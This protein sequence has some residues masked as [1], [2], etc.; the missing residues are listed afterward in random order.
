MIR[1]F[2]K[3]ALS[4][5]LRGRL[6]LLVVF[7]MVPVTLLTV[8]SGWR[9]RQETVRAAEENLQ[10]VT[11][12]AAANEAR[13]IE[14]AR[15]F[16]T[17]L[18]SVPDVL[19]GEASC[20]AYLASL[21]HKSDGYADFGVINLN[22][23]VICSAAPLGS[24]T[25]LH[26]SRDFRRAVAERKF[27]VGGHVADRASG[28]PTV[29]FMY[30]V[31]DE[32]GDALA[33]VFAALDLD[34]LDQF[35][36]DID[37]PPNGE[38]ITTDGNGIIISQRPGAETAIGHMVPAPLYDGMVKVGFGTT[39][40]TG[41]DD[42]RRLNAFA[43]VGAPGETAFKVTVGIPSADIVAAASQAQRSKLLGLLLVTVAALLAAWFV[44][45]IVVLR[46]VKMLV[47]AA[48]AIAAGN[49]HTATG[50]PY[51]TDEIGQLARRFDAMI[52]SLRQYDLESHYDK[53][54]LYSEKERA[55]VTL[56][57][58][59]DAVITT[60]STGNVDYMNRVAERLTGWK[61]ADARGIPARLVFNIVRD[62]TR[63]PAPNSLETALA[64]RRVVALTE[65][66]KLL[67]RRG[68]EYAVED[69]AA[70]IFDT[71]RNLIGAVL[72]FRDVT[73]SRSLTAQ[74]AYQA[75]HDPLT[76]LCNRLEF[77]RRLRAI[78]D[79]DQSRQH[80][81]LYV[82]LDRFKHVND[83]A[84]HAAGD[85]LLRNLT[86]LI[87]PLLRDRDT[88]ARLG[89]DEFAVILENCHPDD[90]RKIAEKLRQAVE[91][92]RLDWNGRQFAVGASIG[93]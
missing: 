17:A 1:Q 7:A 6:L 31:L 18:A 27:I 12:L 72:V 38:L 26:D 45:D 2:L 56:A 40:W 9:D 63:E 91:H 62:G 55:E 79:S 93:V 71:D 43:S 14:G 25:S 11:N 10:R 68:D 16:L 51:G 44:S 84:G 61:V 3:R 75:T 88:F 21:L 92:Y 34:S 66:L 69:T 90:A 46:R 33:V 29:R 52:E 48:D 86:G 76:G 20:R 80:A 54:R 8:H 77:E 89:G 82:D 59:G 19:A 64:E 83:N 28:K 67:S 49:L 65:N 81:L 74:L 23:D 47:R 22:G 85:E 53:A 78:A 35:V 70:P 24:M 60:D 15:Q 32:A 58:I 37:L 13:L 4:D 39:E 5:S 50:I 73:E 87:R 41:R 36:S 57:S 30:P 42:V